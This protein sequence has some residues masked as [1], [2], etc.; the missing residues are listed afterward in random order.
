MRC[1]AQA[2]IPWYE[3]TGATSYYLGKEPYAI[4]EAKE[5]GKGSKSHPKGY[6]A[7]H[8]WMKLDI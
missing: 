2:A 3:C 7:N 1:L 6:M 8:D 4:L 5:K